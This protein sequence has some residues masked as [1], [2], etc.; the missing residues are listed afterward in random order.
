MIHPSYKLSLYK[1]TAVVIQPCKKLTNHPCLITNL[2]IYLSFFLTPPTIMDGGSTPE[3]PP[4][5]V[6]GD[7]T[8]GSPVAG[9]WNPTK[10]Q[11]TMLENLYEQGL[12]TPTAEQIQQITTRLQTYGH[13]EGKNVFYW[14]QN[15]KARQRQKEKQDHH[16]SLFRQ[17]HHH[18]HHQFR[19]PPP[20]FLSLPPSS[21]VLF[22][23]CYMSQNNLGFYGPYPQVVS[24]STS[25]R[26]LPRSANPRSP[27]SGGILPIHQPESVVTAAGGHKLMVEEHSRIVNGRSYGGKETL[28]LF[29]LH[30][31]GILQERENTS[32]S[33]ASCTI[34]TT[35]C[36]LSSTGGVVDRHYFDFFA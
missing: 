31:T 13:I 2:S 21:N 26:R 5:A 23:P 4:A 36:T 29:P 25:R 19:R 6:A 14:F 24:P 3:P 18:H 20:P 27:N 35:A 28:D 10:E 12:R 7:G 11:I 8:S 33:N 22:D 17:Y 34:A 32:I 30:P 16:L 15:H 9:R 1:G